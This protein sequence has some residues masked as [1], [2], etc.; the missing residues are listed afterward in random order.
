[1][2]DYWPLLSLSLCVLS[3][4]K[5]SEL[6]NL[7]HHFQDNFV[8][9]ELEKNHWFVHLLL[10]LLHKC[11]IVCS[12]RYLLHQSW[13]VNRTKKNRKSWVDYREWSYC[14]NYWVNVFLAMCFEYIRQG[15]V[16]ALENGDSTTSTFWKYSPH[17][18]CSTSFH[19]PKWRRHF[20]SLTQ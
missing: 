14:W 17:F 16:S 13:G 7:G 20:Q 15:D 8:F 5:T 3:L 11:Y 6:A 2:D 12:S 18:F 1:M 10:L 19:L 4:C 9:V